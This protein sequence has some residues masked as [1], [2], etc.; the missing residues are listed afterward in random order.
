MLLI[1]ILCVLMRVCR[2]TETYFIMRN[3]HLLQSLSPV[4]ILVLRWY[5]VGT[6]SVSS[7]FD[8]HEEINK[9]YYAHLISYVST[10]YT[11]PRGILIS[12][13][14]QIPFRCQALTWMK[15]GDGAAY[16]QHTTNS[17]ISLMLQI[18]DRLLI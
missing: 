13:P 17:L 5:I 6:F 16:R 3:F 10:I 4:L 18:S 2:E 15:I 11:Q 12:T 7:P 14:L 1:G 8:Y 9:L